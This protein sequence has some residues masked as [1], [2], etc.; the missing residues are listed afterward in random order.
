MIA[1]ISGSAVVSVVIWL[2]VASLIFF[3]LNWL[4]GYIAPPEPFAK[5]LRVVMAIAVAIVLINA[6]LSLAGMP[7]IDWQGR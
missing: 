2:L 1:L 4:I 7:I 3:I 5:I 6:L